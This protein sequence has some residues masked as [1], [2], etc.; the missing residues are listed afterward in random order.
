MDLRPR[1]YADE[2]PPADHPA[3]ADGIAGEKFLEFFKDLE[4][5]SCQKPGKTSLVRHTADG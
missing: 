2:L 3:G 4:A 1:K 5:E